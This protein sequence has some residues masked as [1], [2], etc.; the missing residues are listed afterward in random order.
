MAAHS[1]SLVAALVAVPKLLIEVASL[2]AEHRLQGSRA[3]QSQHTGS[4]AW[5]QLAHRPSCLEACR[6]FPDQESNSGPLHWQVGSFFL[7]GGPFFFLLV[8]G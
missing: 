1:L 8:G 5:A 2:A 4:R 7:G 6:I 3:Q